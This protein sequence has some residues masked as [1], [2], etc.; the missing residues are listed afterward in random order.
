M[1][2]ITHPWALPAYVVVWQ[3]QQGATRQN[4]LPL[5]RNHLRLSHVM[6]A[7]ASKS[8]CSADMPPLKKTD[9]AN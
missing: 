7:R 5:F 6:S 2:F 8:L 3:E 4:P 1:S 9:A